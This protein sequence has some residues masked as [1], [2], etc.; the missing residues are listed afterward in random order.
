MSSYAKGHEIPSTTPLFSLRPDS[1]QSCRIVRIFDTQ[2]GRSP[3]VVSVGRGHVQRHQIFQILPTQLSCKIIW[4]K[5]IPALY[6]KKWHQISDIH[7]YIDSQSAETLFHFNGPIWARKIEIYSC[8]H[9]YPDSSA[10]HVY[11][12]VPNQGAFWELEG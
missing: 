9:W 10:L 4:N 12:D 7:Y 3:L 8:T 11:T 1:Y 2:A 6:H 5:I